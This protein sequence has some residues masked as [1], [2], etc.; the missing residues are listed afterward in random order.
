MELGEVDQRLVAGLAG[1]R[2]RREPA[3]VDAVAR[4]HLGRDDVI[5]QG[6]QG[7]DHEIERS[8]DEQ[9]H[10]PGL[11]VLA[12]PADPPGE[13]LGEDEIA[14]HLRAVGVDAVHRGAL[15]TPVEIAQEVAAVPT[16]QG[17]QTG[18][19]AEGAGH[20]TD[21]VQVVELPGGE[22]R[23]AGHHVRS[24]QRV[25]QVEHGQLALGCEH[26]A[27]EP[28]GAGI[29][30]AGA[31]AGGHLEAGLLN[32]RRQVHLLHVVGPVDNGGIE[33]ERRPVVVVERLPELQEPVELVDRLALG[34]GAVQLDVLVGPA[35]LLAALLKA[36]AHQ[37]MSTSQRQGRQHPV[38]GLQRTLRS[39]ELAGHPPPTGEGPLGHGDRLVVLV[40]DGVL[41][42]PAADQ[43]EELAVLERVDGPAS[44]LDD[45]GAGFH[46]APRGHGHDGRHHEVHRDHVDD[47]L[48]H[49]RE[50]LEQAPGIGGDHRLGHAESPDPSRVGLGQGRLN[51]R[52]PNDAHRDVA[53]SLGESPLAEGLGE[54]IGVREAEAGGPGPAGLG[55]L[56][57]HPASPEALDLLGECRDAGRAE[58]PAGL[59]GQRGQTLGAAAGLLGVAAGAAG[60]VHLVAPA[61]LGEE[62]RVVHQLLGGGAPAAAGHVAGRHRDQVGLRAGFGQDCG[63]P[64]RPE[65]VDLHRVVEGRVEVHGGRRM[66]HD[67]AAGQRGPAFVVEVEPVDADVAG[68]RGDPASGHLLVA[69]A[70]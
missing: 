68:H 46:R 50:L 6:L 48:G 13:R 63:H 29:G 60:A 18:R 42:E 12:D 64:A 51:D 43:V 26:L 66:D 55:H 17:Q 45:I 14:E 25:L 5:E 1:G 35:Q 24:D 33:A 28:G 10:V 27:A 3:V 53:A 36:G 9:R 44:D 11:P 34:V 15:E 16:V 4:A 70:A 65:Q 39:L 52:G 20:E 49:A 31:G 38:G 56:L 32:H 21:P 8:G 58:F 59:S 7:S 61:D 47:A 22:P 30:A 37:G 41:G 54:G 19:L 40:V 69:L 67:V 2:H 57:V 62:R 23:V